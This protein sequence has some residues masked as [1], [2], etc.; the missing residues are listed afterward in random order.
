MSDSTALPSEQ[1]H[2]N[3]LTKCFDDIM[4]TAAEMLV[5]QQMKSIQLSSDIAAGFTQSQHKLLGEKVHTFHSIL[6][7]LDLTLTTA[8]NCVDKFAAE[9]AAR[10]EK[11]LEEQ[12][13]QQIEQEKLKREQEDQKRLIEAQKAS[14][15]TPFGQ[16][17][18]PESTP[19]TFLNELSKSNLSGPN[20]NLKEIT[21]ASA[22]QNDANDN[23]NGTG[24]SSHNT[25]GGHDGYSTGLNDLNDLD[26]S[27]FGGIEQNDLGLGFDEVPMAANN[28]DKNLNNESGLNDS[29]PPRGNDGS[30]QMLG[31]DPS[32][33]NTDS[34]L[35]LNDFNDLGLDWNNSD[36]QNGLDMSEFNI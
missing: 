31:N 1:R 25:S 34:Y 3:K 11:L 16:N 20:R 23:T 36:A 14:E 13:V 4:K 32:A 17:D 2:Q 35:T 7:D 10:R 21:T 28:N 5:Q 29:A 26:L 27:M 6:D 30:N 9:A 19:T 33:N 8:K 15:S 24:G 18:Y 22:G 12:R